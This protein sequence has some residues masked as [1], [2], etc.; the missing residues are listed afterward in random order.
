MKIHKTTGARVPFMRK[1]PELGV[2]C[3]VFVTIENDTID[4]NFNLFSE[5][6]Y[7]NLPY[8]YPISTPCDQLKLFLHFQTIKTYF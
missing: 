8:F 6:K 7:W 5:K 4:G 1:Y 3:D 2:L